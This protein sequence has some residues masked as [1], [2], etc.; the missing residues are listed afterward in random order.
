LGDV[1]DLVRR[2]TDLGLGREACIARCVQTAIRAP[3]HRHETEA[4]QIQ[5]IKGEL[6]EWL[7]VCDDDRIE[8]INSMSQ[9][10]QD[11]TSFR[12]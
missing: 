1:A 7:E 8:S 5:R 3:R 10:P 11:V 6:L 9:P 4:D 12:A 2:V